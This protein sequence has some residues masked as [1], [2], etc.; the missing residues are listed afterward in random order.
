MNWR[1]RVSLIAGGSPFHSAECCG[2]DLGLRLSTVGGGGERPVSYH[3]CPVSSAVACD[4]GKVCGLI[5]TD[6]TGC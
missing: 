2:S 6:G 1:E 4:C 5:E 3:C